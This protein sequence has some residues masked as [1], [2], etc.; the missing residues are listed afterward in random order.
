[1]QKIGLYLHS[2]G[3][4]GDTPFIY[5]IYGLAGIPEGFSRKCALHGGTFMLNTPIEEFVFHEE[6]EKKGKV[7]AVKSGENEIKTDMVICSPDLPKCKQALL[8]AGMI[9]ETGR[10]I[11]AILIL[12]KLPKKVVRVVGEE[13]DKKKKN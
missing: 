12:D 2:I 7:K 3:A 11:R 5:P 13:E 9:Q 1:M 4:Y 6:G 10:V 8:K